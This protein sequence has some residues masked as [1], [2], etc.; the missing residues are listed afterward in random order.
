MDSV[1]RKGREGGTG[2]ERESKGGEKRR[3]GPKERERGKLRE[4]RP[5]GPASRKE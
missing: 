4:G 1:N 3:R 2:K 5:R